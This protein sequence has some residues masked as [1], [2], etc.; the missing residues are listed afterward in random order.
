MEENI[1]KTLM[2]PFKDIQYRPFY[3]WV[4]P[5]GNLQLATLA[6]SKRMCLAVTRVFHVHGVGVSEETMKAKGFRIEKVYLTVTID[7]GTVDPIEKSQT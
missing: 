7:E 5:D 1:I 3:V 2:K 4:A 6:E